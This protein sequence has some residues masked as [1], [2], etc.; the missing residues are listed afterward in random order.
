MYKDT[1]L[2]GLSVFRKLSTMFVNYLFTDFTTFNDKR[3]I[4]EIQGESDGST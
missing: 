3:K 4:D 1:N 2:E